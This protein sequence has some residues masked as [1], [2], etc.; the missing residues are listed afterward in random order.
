M[1]RGSAL[2]DAD[3]LEAHLGDPDLVV[4]EVDEKPR[5]YRLGHVPGAHCLDWKADIQQSRL[6]EIPGPEAV[7]ELWRDMGVTRRSTVVF[8]GDKSNWY[9]SYGLW[10]F[11]HYGLTD[12]RLLDGGRQ[13]WI[14]EERPLS[15]EMPPKADGK[16]VPRAQVTDG[17]RTAWHE[18]PGAVDSGSQLLD[19]RTAPEYVGS[20]LTEPGYL[21]E[22]AQRPGHIPSALGMPWDRMIDA[23]GL[24]L[25]EDALREELDLHGVDLGRPT[26]LYCRIGERSAHTWFVLSQVLDL[27]ASN[28]DGSW[29]EWGSMIG[30]PIAIGDEP[31]DAADLRVAAEIHGDR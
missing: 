9:A 1:S 14:V 4:V 24:L 27:E 8:Y 11:R 26:I 13:R 21:D 6:R 7:R 30:M 5:V 16:G 17:L 22:S 25:P 12:V 19:V 2:V 3:W 28:Y 20:V 10:L 31:G 23:Q 29:I 15:T 18:I